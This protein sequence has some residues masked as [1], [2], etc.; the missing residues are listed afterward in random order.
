MNTPAK[1]WSLALRLA[2]SLHIVACSARTNKRNFLTVDHPPK[3]RQLLLARMWFMAVQRDKDVVFVWISVRSLQ[4][5][6]TGPFS[7]VWV[8]C[9]TGALVPKWEYTKAASAYE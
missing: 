8:V 7:S 4:S 1:G 5:R 9:P 2:H 6:S 3:E